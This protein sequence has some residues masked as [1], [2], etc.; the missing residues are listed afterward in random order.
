MLKSVGIVRGVDD[1]GRLVIPKGLR[2]SLDIKP[3]DVF[4]IYTDDDS[5]VLKKYNP[6]DIF[7]GE[8]DDLVEYKGKKVSVN[9]IKELARIAGLKVNE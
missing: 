6:A 4:E 3:G 9:T 8:M 1:V 5:I 2:K 7:T